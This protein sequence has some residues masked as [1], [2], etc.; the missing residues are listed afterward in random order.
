MDQKLLYNKNTFFKR[1]F[2]EKCYEGINRFV[3]IKQCSEMSYW[4]NNY[5]GAIFEI[6]DFIN[7]KGSKYIYI[8]ESNVFIYTTIQ[9]EDFLVM[10]NQGYI[11]KKDCEV[12][13]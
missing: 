5:I 4:Y 13:Q 6:K 9:P 8:K 10:S 12:I 11:L 7:F 1:V 3:L 2:I